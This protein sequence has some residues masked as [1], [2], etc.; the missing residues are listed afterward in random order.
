MSD[1]LADQLAAALIGMIDLAMNAAGVDPYD[2]DLAERAL[3]RYLFQADPA[4]I[5]TQEVH[6]ALKHISEGP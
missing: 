6:G 5:L 1:E 3:Q 2:F 4:A